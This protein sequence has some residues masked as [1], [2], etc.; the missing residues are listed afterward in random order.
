MRT[1]LNGIR[2]KLASDFEKPPVINGIMKF[3]FVIF[4]PVW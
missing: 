2:E 1:T 3:S 4:I